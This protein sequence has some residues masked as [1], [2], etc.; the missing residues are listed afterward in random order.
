[1][2]V[3][4]EI[5]P[6][7]VVILCGGKGT[8]LREE[9]EYRPKP[10][11]PIGCQPILWHI[12]KTYAHYGFKEFV[13]CL[14]YKGDTIKDYFLNYSR[15]ASDVT[16]KLG[17]PGE[18]VFHNSHEE[19]DWTV[20]LANTGEDTMTGGRVKRVQQYVDGDAF[21]LT[22]GDGVGDVDLKALLRFHQRHGK[23]GT[24]T[25]VRPPGRFGEMGI[26]KNRVMEFNEKPQASG[27]IINGGFFVFNRELFRFLNDDPN[28]IFEQQ[29]LR[30]LAARKQLM[31]FEHDGFWQP[32][33]TF[34]E[35]EL[36]NKLWDGGRAPWKVW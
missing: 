29:P 19:E 23:I 2:P 20:T 4:D 10:M 30:S 33:D 26:T 5:K 36:L 13:L 1:V 6:M 21:M 18:A 12:M 15:L 32:M 27:G 35:F 7:K 22:Y 14:G 25:G 17:K 16:V 34:R 24:V 3:S 31:C 28:L 11:V 8:R 9:T